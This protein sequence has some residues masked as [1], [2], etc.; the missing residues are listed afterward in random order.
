MDRGWNGRRHFWRA[1]PR[2]RPR[3]WRFSAF[4]RG[5]LVHG[6]AACRSRSPAASAACTQSI[7]KEFNL[8]PGNTEFN[9]LTSETVETDSS[10]PT[11]ATPPSGEAQPGNGGD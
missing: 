4:L 5:T 2:G 11:P 1:A 7:R 9:D 3:S 10:E 6:S 8:E